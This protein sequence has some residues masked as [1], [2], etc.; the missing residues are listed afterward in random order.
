MS[1]EK[2]LH[3]ADQGY[4]VFPVSGKRPLVL[5]WQKRATTDP[6][7]VRAMW[8]KDLDAGVGIATGDGLVVIDLDVKGGTDGVQTFTDWAAEHGLEWTSTTRTASGG[9]HVY[10]R[11]GEAYRNRAG[12]LPGVDVRADGGYVVAY[13]AVPPLTDLP[14]IT[15]PLARLL[16]KR[17][18]KDDKGAAAREI[19]PAGVATAFDFEV[20]R[21]QS[22]QD[23]ERNH[24]LNATAYNLGQLVG[25]HLDADEVREALTDA[26]LEAGLE[27]DEIMTTL[28]SGLNDGMRNP[29][30]VVD[31]QI[32]RAHV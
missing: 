28:E 3:L 23:G 18:E 4:R 25:D 30:T 7:K 1:L 2:A 17:S 5:E 12:M 22:A 24:V 21:M 20:M 8:A 13:D 11:A 27:P 9:A 10:L 15:E 16:P 14:Q 6:E 26:A 19:G 32:G 31:Q 29:R